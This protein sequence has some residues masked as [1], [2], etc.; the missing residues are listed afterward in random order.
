MQLDNVRLD[1]EESIAVLAITREKQLNSLNTA[2]LREMVEALGSLGERRAPPVLALIVTGQGKSFVAGAD[3][4][5]MS[6][7][8][9]AEAREFAA[10]GHRAFAMLESLAIP[11]IAAVNGYALGGGCELALACDLVLA[12][13]KAK[14]GQ[15]EVNFGII[16]GFGGTQRLVRAIGRQRAKQMIFTGEHIGGAR[17]AEIGLALEVLPADR[18]LE[19]AREIAG[20]IASKGPVAISQAKRVINWGADADLRNGNELEQQAFSLLFGTEDQKEGMRAFL[21]KR[22][23]RFLGR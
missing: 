7:M 22:R 10:L 21:E 6:S 9:V 13:E 16:P 12:S 15:P 11:T 19:R 20:K 8:S 14:F 18:L 23:A 2:T 5:E 1:F 17:A 3:I 4:E